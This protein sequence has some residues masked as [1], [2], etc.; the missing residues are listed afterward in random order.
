VV[1][2][3]VVSGPVPVVGP[4]SRLSTLGRCDHGKD[5]IVAG[6]GV[7]QVEDII[8]VQIEDGSI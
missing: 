5:E 1:I 8:D 4:I 7:L 3:V 6:S 2:A